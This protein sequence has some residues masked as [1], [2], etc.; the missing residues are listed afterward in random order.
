MAKKQF[1]RQSIYED[2]INK[3][4]K[5]AHVSK[6][7][8]HMHSNYS[9]GKPTIE[10]IIEYTEN[11]TDLIIIAITDHNTIEGAKK[12]AEIVKNG[13][14]RFQV[15]I[16]EEITSK[17][18][19]IVGLF[20]KKK[21]SPHMTVSDTL[22]NIKDQ[23]GISVI[24]HPFNY[25]RMNGGR[26]EVYNGIGAVS[27][28]RER[29]GIDAVEVINATPTS[30]N[31]NFASRFLNETIVHKAESGGSDAHI[32]EGIGQGYTVFEGKTVFDLKKAILL[33]Q[34]KAVGRKWPL[35]SLLKY[36]FFFLP[37]GLR[38]TVYTI[39]HG[40]KSMRSIEDKMINEEILKNR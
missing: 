35:L 13:H 9:D 11:K 19:H 31:E 18:G 5:M 12:A 14:Y 21:V 30:S 10:E 29:N 7:D 33:H 4:R 2:S 28:I 3:L 20:L 40:R 24:P 39:L 26:M 1:I 37:K 38:L 25:T 23:G 27:T 36:L 16:G 15:I 6:A 34:T 32:L 17:E 8:L 22:K